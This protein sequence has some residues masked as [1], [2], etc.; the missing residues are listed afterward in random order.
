M[1][2]FVGL[3]DSASN[4]SAAPLTR[5]QT[6]SRSSA[7][8]QCRDAHN[9]LFNGSDVTGIVLRPNVD[10]AA[11]RSLYIGGNKQRGSGKHKRARPQACH[12]HHR[13]YRDFADADRDDSGQGRGF[14]QV[15]HDPRQRWP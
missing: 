2:G 7:L 12:R 15:L 13:N 3:V 1:S 14:G 11:L 4:E 6:V 10:T 5:P 9:E 8:C